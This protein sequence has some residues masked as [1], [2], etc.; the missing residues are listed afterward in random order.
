MSDRFVPEWADD[1]M[2]A[3]NLIDWVEGL[4]MGIIYRDITPHRIAI[5][6]PDGNFWDTW[7]GAF[8]NAGTAKRTLQ[9]YGVR[10]YWYGF[11]GR[12]VYFHVAKRQAS[13]ADGLLIRAG[14]PTLTGEHDGRRSAWAHRG[15]AMPRAWADQAEERKRQRR[16]QRPGLWARI[17]RRQ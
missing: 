15:H 7:R 5:P 8:W 2:G 9:R 1:I 3:L 11:N 6:H 14:V 12:E 10:V 13:W 17:W 4:I 16:R